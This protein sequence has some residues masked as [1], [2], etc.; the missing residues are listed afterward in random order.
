MQ[1]RNDF[2]NWNTQPPRSYRICDR[3]FANIFRSSIRAEQ[4]RR[5]PRVR[6]IESQM[7]VD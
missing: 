6:V 1:I 2:R 3:K 7:N 5:S 4:S